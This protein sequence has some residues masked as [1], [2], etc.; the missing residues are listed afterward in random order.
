MT[1]FNEIVIDPVPGADLILAYRADPSG[2][3]AI[4]VVIT[5]PL[6]DHASSELIYAWLDWLAAKID[7]QCSRCG[8]IASTPPALKTAGPD[9]VVSIPGNDVAHTADCTASRD[10]LDALE[11]ACSPDGQL[12]VPDASIEAAT[13]AAEHVARRMQEQP[14]PESDS[15]T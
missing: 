4:D 7:G 14:N 8:G 9:D 15:T 3:S 1:T 2:P 5:N 13:M 6:P 10:N 12:C 11:R